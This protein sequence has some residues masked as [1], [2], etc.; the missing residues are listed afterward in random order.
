MVPVEPESEA[1]RT[2]THN[3]CFREKIRKIGI[4]LHTPVLLYKIGYKGV[5]VAWTCFPDEAA[6]ITAVKLYKHRS[7]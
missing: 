6:S 1:V 2:S 7:T 3:L 4:P 5:Y